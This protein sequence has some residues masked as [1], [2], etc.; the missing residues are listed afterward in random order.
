MSREDVDAVARRVVELLQTEAME[1]RQ[2]RG[3]VDAATAARLLGVSR[4][5]IYA[6][7]KE[8]GAIRLGNGRRAR[9]R[10]DPRRLLASGEAGASS[11]DAPQRRP[12]RPRRASHE[13]GIEL[14]PILRPAPP[15][16]RRPRSAPQR[17][18]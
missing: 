4:G 2:Q 9:L 6:K 12:P 14:L 13:D 15:G 8:L 5:T 10:F 18:G 7:A 16:S 17:R 1:S 11:T 3:L